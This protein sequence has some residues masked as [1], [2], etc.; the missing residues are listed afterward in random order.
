MIADAL[1]AGL[2]AL[3]VAPSP[4][5]PMGV[6][7]CQRQLML[8]SYETGRGGNGAE[9]PGGKLLSTDW[10]EQ[11]IAD[12]CGATPGA[13]VDRRR[14]DRDIFGSL[15]SQRVHYADLF[16]TRAPEGTRRMSLRRW[17]LGW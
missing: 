5:T 17:P 12:S 16:G 11:V 13:C 14:D 8:E 2:K 4:P 9:R 7:E 15:K 6:P 1:T 3:I 10:R